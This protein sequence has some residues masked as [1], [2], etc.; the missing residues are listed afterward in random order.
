LPESARVLL[1]EDNPQVRA[2]AQDLLEDLGCEVVAAASAEEAL[3]CLADAGPD[4][5]LSDIIMPGMSGVELA[6]EI[7]ALRPDL[8]VVLAT[9]YSEQAAQ[10]AQGQPI[11]LKPY[12]AR[13][14]SAALSQAINR[15]SRKSSRQESQ[16]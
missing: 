11:V 6:K 5:V 1:V 8:P 16:S 13:D 2:F 4:V 3:G 12:S 14:L 7:G 15:A 9:G 10:G